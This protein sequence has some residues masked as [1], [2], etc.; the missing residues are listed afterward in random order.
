MDARKLYGNKYSLS[1]EEQK[2]IDYY[3]TVNVNAIFKDY[4]YDEEYLKSLGEKESD[5]TFQF[6]YDVLN[7]VFESMIVTME[8]KMKD[9]GIIEKQLSFDNLIEENVYGFSIDVTLK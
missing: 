5:E 6:Y 8:I 4:G 7:D 9:G 3:Y 2:E 1:Y